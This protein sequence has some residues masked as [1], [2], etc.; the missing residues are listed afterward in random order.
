MER[1][2]WVILALALWKVATGMDWRVVSRY[3]QGG[4]Q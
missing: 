2:L 4:N 1:M 3:L